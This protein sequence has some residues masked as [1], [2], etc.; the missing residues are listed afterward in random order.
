MA[1]IPGLILAE[2]NPSRIK[3]TK[4]PLLTWVM[5]KPMRSW[6]KPN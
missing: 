5:T 6:E 4:T 2:Q 1:K 3:T